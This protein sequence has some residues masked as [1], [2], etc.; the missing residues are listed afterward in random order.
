MGARTEGDRSRED[1]T[2]G[3]PEAGTPGAVSA[4]QTIRS[5]LF[6]CTHNAIR[7]PMA[8]A[9]LTR[10]AGSRIYSR[11]VGVFADLPLDGFAVAVME[12]IGV[13]I[14]RHNPH[15]FEDL[16]N[17]GEDIDQFDLIIAL[18][19]AAQRHALEHTRYFAVDVEY[20]PV[21]DPT[22]VEGSRERRLEAYR[23]VRDRLE[24]RIK[25]RF[26]ALRAPVV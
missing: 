6:A 9:L 7:S 22:A 8:Q 21:E 18:S 23:E 12:E 20:W 15:T 17:W 14:G 19:P 2:P 11:S 3:A 16:Q 10:F 13:D 5:V 1:R 24:R 26:G 25:L 4:H